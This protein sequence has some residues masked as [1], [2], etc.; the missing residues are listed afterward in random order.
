MSELVFVGTTDE[1]AVGE[2]KIVVHEEA[3]IAVFNVDGDYF[4][5]D[6][7]CPHASGPLDE[8][9]I[10]KGRIICPWHAWSFPLCPVD[11]P[12]DGLPRYRVVVEGDKISVEYPEI[13]ADKGWK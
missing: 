9:F 1:I 13:E 8:G 6:K 7:V 11:A 3:V 5:V 2:S 12:N 4:A 10:E